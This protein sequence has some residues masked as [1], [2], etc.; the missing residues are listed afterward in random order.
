[1]LF[2]QKVIQ[3]NRNCLICSQIVQNIGQFKWHNLS[4]ISI[5]EH[6]KFNHLGNMSETK[7]QLIIQSNSKERKFLFEILITDATIKFLDNK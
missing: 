4:G 7:I 2:V 1:M 6:F 5:K 3:I